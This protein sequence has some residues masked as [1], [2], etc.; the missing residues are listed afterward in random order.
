MQLEAL[1]GAL[2]PEKLGQLETLHQSRPADGSYRTCGEQLGW[3]RIAVPLGTYISTV[4]PIW[5]IFRM[6][7]S[8]ARANWTEGDDGQVG[9]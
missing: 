4:R 1:G 8:S 2:H 7:A 3:D 6:L 9:Q 5:H